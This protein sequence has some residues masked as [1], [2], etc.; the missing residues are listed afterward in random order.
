MENLKNILIQWYDSIKLLKE[1]YVYVI[2]Q[3]KN[4]WEGREFVDICSDKECAIRYCNG[5]ID[6]YKEYNIPI[7]VYVKKQIPGRTDKNAPFGF[8]P[9]QYIDTVYFNEI[10]LMKNKIAEYK[11]TDPVVCTTCCNIL[12]E[13]FED[14]CYNA[15]GIKK[16]NN[17]IVTIYDNCP[18]P[19]LAKDICL[20]NGGMS[21]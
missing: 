16:D 8:I 20:M 19:K 13:N 5:I 4:E 12:G 7:K 18:N 2:E 17:I 6:N 21:V 10:P 14:T 3:E 9:T 11:F 1:K 15:Y